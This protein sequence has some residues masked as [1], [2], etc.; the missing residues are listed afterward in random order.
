MFFLF[1]FYFNCDSVCVYLHP[2]HIKHA[3]NLPNRIPLSTLSLHRLWYP[4][5]LLKKK[6]RS[7]YSHYNEQF[8]T[9]L[10]SVFSTP[11]SLVT[12]YGL[13]VQRSDDLCSE[14]AKLRARRAYV[15]YVL[16]CFTCLRV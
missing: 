16:T 13:F 6:L 12:L 7:S 11:S 4:F 15:L 1:C 8:N 10:L 9:N 5:D 2:C 14:S 3:S